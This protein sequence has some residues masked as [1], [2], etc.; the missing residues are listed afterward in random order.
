MAELSGN[1]VSYRDQAPG[2]PVTSGSRL[3]GLN[4]RVDFF[5]TSIAQVR[6][7]PI[8]DAGE[9]HLDSG[10]QVSSSGEPGTDVP[11]CTNS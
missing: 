11:S 1:Q 9:V 3:G 2:G 6:C 4:Q 10:R 5:H 7:S 8:E